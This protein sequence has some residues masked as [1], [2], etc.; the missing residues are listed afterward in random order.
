[1]TTTHKFPSL[2]LWDSGSGEE[3]GEVGALQ[4]LRG[5]GEA[6]VVGFGGV[7]GRDEDHCRGGGHLFQ[8]SG[9]QVHSKSK[10]NARFKLDTHFGNLV[11]T[12]TDKEMI[13]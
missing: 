9:L 8:A 11:G 10:I 3:K 1:M 6:G 12:D 2:E 13:M 7:E 5:D 4:P